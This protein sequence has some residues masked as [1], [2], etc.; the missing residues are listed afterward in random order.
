MKKRIAYNLISSA[1]FV[2]VVLAVWSVAVVLVDN[3]YVLPPLSEV[4]TSMLKIFYVSEFYTAYFSTLLHAFIGFV[5]SFSIGFAL[6]VL[7]SVNKKVRYVLA[8]LV[9]SVRLVPTMAIALILCLWVS[10]DLAPAIVAFIVVMPTVYSSSLAVFDGVD[11]DL[12]V[13]AKAYGVN[14]S[15][16]A[17][18]IIVPSC[19]Q[20]VASSLASAFSLTLKLTVGAEVLVGALQSMGGLMYYAKN[21]YLDPS[22]VFAVT[23]WIVITGIVG[24]AGLY[25]LRKVVKIPPISTQTKTEEITQGKDITLDSVSVK[26]EDVSVLEGIKLHVKAGQKV[27]IMGKSG[28]GKTTLL[29]AISHLTDYTGKIDSKNDYAFVFQTDRL[30]PF[31]SPMQNLAFVKEGDGSEILDSMGLKDEKDKAVKNLSGGMARRVALSR[32][33]HKNASCILADEPFTGLDVSTKSSI[34]NAL[35]PLIKDKTFLLVTH[36][37]YSAYALCDQIV[38]ISDKKIVKIIETATF[39]REKTEKFLESL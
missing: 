38:V 11:K 23:L 10:A 24:Q 21:V 15:K 9:S 22:L 7:G 19:L 30:I 32:A 2:V 12:L 17:K 39:S 37:L 20:G 34:L 13:M 16:T 1:L 6:A 3:S 35:K 18:Q 29:K 36:D 33:V 27:A 8:P 31:L 28:S 5:L 14:K 25:S 4:V 26:Y